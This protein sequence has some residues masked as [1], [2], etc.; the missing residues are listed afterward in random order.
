VA[1]KNANG[2]QLAVLK[3]GAQ[4]DLS[5]PF[6]IWIRKDIEPSKQHAIASLFA[7]LIIVNTY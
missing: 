1:V 5:N 6:L 4:G 2:D 7:M 3:F